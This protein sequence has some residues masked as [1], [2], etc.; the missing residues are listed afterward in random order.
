MKKLK[1]A[2]TVVIVLGLFLAGGVWAW[3]QIQ[4]VAL[5]TAG[6]SVVHRFED[7]ENNTVCYVSDQNGRYGPT[8]TSI[9]CVKSDVRTSV[10]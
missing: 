2:Q 10:K 8:G 4:T 9:S 6:S 1:K 5:V 3:E 7:K